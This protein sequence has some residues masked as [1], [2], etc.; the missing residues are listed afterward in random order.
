[1]AEQTNNRRT[2]W[3]IG[4][5]VILLLVV[6]LVLLAGRGQPP[7]IQV[8]Q[9]AREDLEASITSNGKVE[10]ISPFV[11]RAQYP[12]FV[13][14]V[15]AKEGQAV[16]KGQIIVTLNSSDVQSQ[17]STS[18]ADLLTAQSELRNARAGGPPDEVAQLDGDLKKAESQV[19]HLE[20][21]QSRI[22]Q[23]LAKQAATQ[24]DLDKNALD[25]AAARSTL[26]T[27]QQKKEGLAQRSSLDVDR[28]S[29]RVQQD[30][31][32]IRSLDEK[33][34]SATVQVP[35]DGT[36]YSLPVR[37]RDYLAVGQ[38]IAQVADLHRV[39]VRAFVDEPDIGWLAPG[40]DVR[41]TWDA[42]PSREWKGRTEQIPKQVV[43]HGARSVGEVLCS[44]DNA[45]LELLPNVNV[46]LKIFVRQQTHVLAVSRAAVRT[47]GTRRYVFQF[48]NGHVRRKD[49]TV[50]IASAAKYE[51]LS[52]LSEGDRVAIPGDIELKD[53]TAVRATEAK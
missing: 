1:M 43:A 31:E 28:A 30:T 32:Q 45:Q 9:V 34:R 2:A 42:M 50:G 52:G 12:T 48:D 53:G 10:P 24:A 44:V 51:V 41:I 49:V 40:Q 11:F 37:L 38:E 21:M 19:T 25:L 17:L 5:A 15:N 7:E 4:G 3:F 33:V 22:E 14:A 36:L 8:V 35:V 29:L 6:V 16:R 18:R 46:S 27:L 39:Q 47:D 13:T 23:L 20:Q 26:K